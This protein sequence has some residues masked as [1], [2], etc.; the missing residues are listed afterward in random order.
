[1]DIEPSVMV[2]FGAS[3]D[4]T[5][6]KLIPALFDRFRAGDL[7]DRFAIVGASRTRLTDDDFRQRVTPQAARGEGAPS[8]ADFARHLHYQPL[9]YDQIADYRT[10]A[11]RLDG[12]AAADGIGG[13]RLYNLAIPPTL[14]HRVALRLAEVGLAAE[15]GD[16]WV[17]LV[18]EKPFGRD[19]ASARELDLAIRSGF[20]EHQVFRI[21]HY[22]A[23]D[24]VQN[25]LMLRFANSIFEPLWNRRYVDYV[26]IVATESLGV[27]HRAGYY[28]GTGVLRDMFQ[29]HMMQLLALVAAEP[30]SVFGANRVRDERVKLFRALRPFSAANKYDHLVLGQYVAGQVGDHQLPAYRDEPGVPPESLTPTYATLRAHVDNWRWQGVPFFLTSGKRLREKVTKIEIQFKPVP[31]SM[32]RDLIDA[33]IS[34]NRLSLGIYPDK[35]ISLAIVAKKPGAKTTLKSIN[36]H[37]DYDGGFEAAAIDAYGKSLGD[38]LRGDHMLFWRQDGLEETWSYFE[39]LINACEECDARAGYL[40]AYPAGSDG[41]VAAQALLPSADALRPALRKD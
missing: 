35:E 11:G 13:N 38:A 34:A 19:L 10:L 36:L 32:F 33:P 1:M 27:E 23:K 12:L 24:T 14:Y 2:I 18:V 28:D 25:I 41:P 3:G 21:D 30:P 9:D 22:L 40:H 39:P 4:L 6:R 8:W 16:R 17:R 20:E 37:F 29:N 5:E 26:N 15:E 7:P 31:H